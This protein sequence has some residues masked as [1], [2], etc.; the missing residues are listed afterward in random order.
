MVLWRRYALSPLLSRKRGLDWTTP[1]APRVGAVR[2]SQLRRVLDPPIVLNFMVLSR[3]T[4]VRLDDVLRELLR[5][6]VDAHAIQPWPCQLVRA[7]LPALPKL[8]STRALAALLAAR[9]FGRIRGRGYS[10]RVPCLRLHLLNFRLRL[11]HLCGRKRQ[12]KKCHTSVE[13]EAPLLTVDC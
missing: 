3:S 1:G 9:G 5:R 4:K 13:A 6:R 2:A 7:Q 12:D 10:T 11:T 8:C